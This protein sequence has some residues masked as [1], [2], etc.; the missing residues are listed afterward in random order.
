MLEFEDEGVVDAKA[1]GQEMALRGGVSGVALYKTCAGSSSRCLH[2][3][4]PWS[5]AWSFSF[6]GNLHSDY[7]NSNKSS[8]SSRIFNSLAMACRMKS[9]L[10]SKAL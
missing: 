3:F 4:P 2:Q 1:Q 8:T 6:P 10:L 5:L 7:S 9:K